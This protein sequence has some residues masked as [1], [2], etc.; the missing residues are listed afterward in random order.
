MNHRFKKLSL[1]FLTCAGI[2][3]IVL[4]A[5][6]EN[7]VFFVTPTDISK[8]PS[9]KTRKN[10]R[11]GGQVLAGSLSKQGMTV[12]FQV[13][14]GTHTVSVIYEGV[15][16]DLF[17]EN[18]GVVALGFFKGDNLF[19]ARQILAKHDERYMPK[20]VADKLKEQSVWRG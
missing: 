1:I 19:Q 17:K 10:L 18:Q 16:P 5:M 13:T 2:T 12:R 6:R 9:L 4:G 11:L 20:D 15:P 8:N 14:D 7:I 3:L